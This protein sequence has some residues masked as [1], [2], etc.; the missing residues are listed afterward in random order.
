MSS[1]LAKRVVSALAGVAC[2]ALN[3]L[4]S[5]V[6]DEQAPRQVPGRSLES[7]ML[8]TVKTTTIRRDPL[9]Q[10]S[11]SV[12][13]ETIR[14]DGRGRSRMDRGDIVAVWGSNGS[15]A[16]QV[17]NRKT[18][19][20]LDFR[21]DG[22]NRSGPLAGAE[23]KVSIGP[24]VNR[25]DLGEREVGGAPARGTRIAYEVPNPLDADAKP[26]EVWT[27][28]WRGLED[29]RLLMKTTFSSATQETKI[30]EY[31][32]QTLQDGEL[33]EETFELGSD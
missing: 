21:R 22:A 14:T 6:A 31:A 5:A 3:P 1:K 11:R 18:G 20:I 29:G 7:P 28:T 9:G 12:T 16:P 4:Y 26:W 2:A 15:P 30:V 32:Y 25:E 19:E 27:E 13:S 8:I 33:S 23:P 17:M 24:E 10:T